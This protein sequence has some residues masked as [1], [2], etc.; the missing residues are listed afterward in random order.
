MSIHIYV[1]INICT[2]THTYIYKISHKIQQKNNSERVCRSLKFTRG[3]V[4]DLPRGASRCFLNM[5]RGRVRSHV[6][7]QT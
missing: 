5:K 4:T 2:Y 6:V 1:Y 7:S 3:H